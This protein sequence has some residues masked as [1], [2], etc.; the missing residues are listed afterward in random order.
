MVLSECW[1]LFALKGMLLTGQCTKYQAK[2]I[3]DLL[4]WKQQRF[5]LLSVDCQATKEMNLNADESELY[6]DTMVLR[7]EPIDKRC[8]KEM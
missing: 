6:S 2:S 8:C 5:S 1:Y 3:K 4:Q 7:L